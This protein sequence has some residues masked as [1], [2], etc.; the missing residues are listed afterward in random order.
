MLNKEFEIKNRDGAVIAKES[1][2]GDLKNEFEGWVDE[3]ASIIKDGFD[4]EKNNGF[5]S[6]LEKK[7]NELK[8]DFC[9]TI[10]RN[11]DLNSGK[12]RDCVNRFFKK[13]S[14]INYLKKGRNADLVFWFPLNQKDIIASNIKHFEALSAFLV[15]SVDFFGTSSNF[16]EF[17]TSSGSNQLISINNI[18]FNEEQANQLLAYIRVF[19][20]TKMNEIKSILKK[21]R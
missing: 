11:E 15:E 13:F 6:F 4:I 19:L 12:R 16:L 18:K 21:R 1:V 14:S 9:E 7:I 10:V 2:S 8:K 5:D 17:V 20:K 3:L